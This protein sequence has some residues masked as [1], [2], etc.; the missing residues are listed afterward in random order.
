M[1]LSIA[2]PRNLLSYSSGASEPVGSRLSG[3]EVGLYAPGATGGQ[4]AD[5]TNELP[6]RWG[7]EM[8]VRRGWGIRGLRRAARRARAYVGKRDLA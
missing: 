7:A 5:Q 1:R 8:A 2:E 3:D 4:L 6:V